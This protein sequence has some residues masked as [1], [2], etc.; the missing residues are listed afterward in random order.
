MLAFYV[1]NVSNVRAYRYLS[2]LGGALSICDW[3]DRILVW[4]MTMCIQRKYKR[5][6]SKVPRELLPVYDDDQLLLSDTGGE[7]G[8]RSP[9]RRSSY[10]G[11]R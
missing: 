6:R 2:A 4:L 9:S 3:G 1:G 10:S 8:G 5:A 11:K 7:G